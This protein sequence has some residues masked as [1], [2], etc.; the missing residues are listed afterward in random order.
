MSG[1]ATVYPKSVSS[2]ENWLTETHPQTS[3]PSKRARTTQQNPFID[4][5][6]DVANEGEEDEDDVPDAYINDSGML[7]LQV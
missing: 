6:A 2:K 7:T 3:R 4:L 5:E 1:I